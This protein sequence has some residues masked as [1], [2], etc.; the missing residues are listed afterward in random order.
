LTEYVV[1]RYYRAPEVMLSSCEYTETVD[2]WSLGCTFAEVLS[3]KIL[4]P[5]KHYLEQVE[6]IVDVCGTPDDDTLTQISNENARKYIQ[7][8]P[9]K[10]KVPLE[11]VFKTAPE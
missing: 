6:L 2:I 1:T 5:G 3:G 11:K 7:K 10:D 8:L 4:F 9:K